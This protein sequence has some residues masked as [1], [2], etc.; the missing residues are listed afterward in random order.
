MTD[1]KKKLGTWE[2]I[3]KMSDEDMDIRLA[4]M[5]NIISINLKADHGEV[6]FGIDKNTALDLQL[7]KEFGGGFLLFDMETF[8]KL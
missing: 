7:G 8:N 1:V 3:Q 5:K 6:T 2:K 4:P